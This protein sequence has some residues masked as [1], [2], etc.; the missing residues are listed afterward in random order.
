MSTRCQ[1]KL[2]NP[3]DETNIYIY[4]HSDGYPENVIP[5][6]APFVDRF[7]KDR[8]YDDAYLL[9]QIVRAFAVADLKD[10]ENNKFSRPKDGDSFCHGQDYRGWG[11]DTVQHGDIEYLYEIDEK[12]NIF[13]NGKKITKAA[14][15]KYLNK[16]AA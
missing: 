8:G 3:S 12:G 1:I 5:T 15:A 6:L 14:L 2:K 13:I 16:K 7:F 11:L 10:A 4:K 9:C